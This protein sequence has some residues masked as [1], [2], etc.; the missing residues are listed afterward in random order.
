MILKDSEGN[1]KDDKLEELGRVVARDLFQ[2]HKQ[3]P[4]LTNFVFTPILILVYYFIY[5]F[6]YNDIFYIMYNIT[7]NIIYNTLLKPKS[8]NFQFWN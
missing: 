8:T 6:V 2:N 7:F 4:I 1:K 3:E 5:K